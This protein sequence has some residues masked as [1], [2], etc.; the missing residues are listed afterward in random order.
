MGKPL[1]KLF[2]EEE[3]LPMLDKI[4]TY[5]NENANPLKDLLQ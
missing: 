3:I 2:K 4:M 5:Y 1:N